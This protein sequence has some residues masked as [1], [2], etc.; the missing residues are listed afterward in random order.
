MNSPNFPNIFETMSIIL[1]MGFMCFKNVLNNPIPYHNHIFK[2]EIELI[3]MEYDLIQRCQECESCPIEM[4][5]TPPQRL[6]KVLGQPFPENHIHREVIEQICGKNYDQPCQMKYALMRLSCNDRVAVQNACVAIFLWDLGKKHDRL[7]DFQEGSS[8]WTEE[9]NLGR[10]FRESY[11]IR[12]RDIWK[13]GLRE[14]GKRQSIS[15]LNIYETIVGTP[16]TYD[17]G[18]LHYKNLFDEHHLRD[19]CRLKI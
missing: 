19:S 12:F 15:V 18:I 10:G 5:L 6:K 16:E 7:V 14:K 13:L 4:M 9:I 1:E 8:I 17:I 3:I 11:A 2:M